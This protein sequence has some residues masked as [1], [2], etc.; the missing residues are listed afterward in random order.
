MFDMPAMV[1]CMQGSSDG[2]CE[3]ARGGRGDEM[4]HK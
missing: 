3:E 2:E 4:L 1:I